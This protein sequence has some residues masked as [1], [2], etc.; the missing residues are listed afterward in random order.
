MGRN[1]IKYALNDSL[2]PYFREKLDRDA[3]KLPFI[4]IMFDEILSEIFMCLY[5]FEKLIGTRLVPGYII[6]NF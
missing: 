3:D 6:H 2:Y 5:A 1:K 4:T